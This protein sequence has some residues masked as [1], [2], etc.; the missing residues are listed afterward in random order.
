MATRDNPMKWQD[1]LVLTTL[2]NC[3]ICLFVSSDRCRAVEVEADGVRSK[4]SFS[5]CRLFLSLLFVFDP[6]GTRKPIAVPRY[7]STLHYPLTW[8][9]TTSAL[10]YAE[11]LRGVLL[12]LPSSID[13]SQGDDLVRWI[14]VHQ[15]DL[16]SF[17]L[18]CKI[19]INKLPDCLRIST[20][21]YSPSVI[22]ELATW[23]NCN[24]HHHWA[25]KQ[26]FGPHNIHIC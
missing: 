18:L 4:I 17:F 26:F 7:S 25:Q 14:K 13:L 24:I 8:S 10:L 3:G 23:S 20:V 9:P 16:S 11:V 2:C 15:H 1:P 22:L 21:E 12:Y 5:S 19:K 6:S